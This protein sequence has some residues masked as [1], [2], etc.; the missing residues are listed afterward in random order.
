MAYPSVTY[1]FANDSTADATEVNSNFTDIINGFSDGSKNLNMN[2]ATFAGA[3]T[4]NA[5]VTI[6]NAT[7]DDLTVTSRLASDL[8]PKTD[9]TYD[10]GSTALRYATA[11]IDA[12]TGTTATFDDFF[13]SLGS[14]GSPSY[15][16]AGDTDTG[17]YSSG[18]NTINF[19]TGG[20][21]AMTIASSGDTTFTGR[22]NI[23][24]SSGD[25]VLTLKSSTPKTYDM[26][27]DSTTFKINNT[28]IAN[29]LEHVQGTNTIK[30]PL[31]YANTSVTSA[32]LFVSSSGE[33][34]RATS[35]IRYKKDVETLDLDALSN[36]MSIRP[37]YFYD[38]GD[39]ENKTRAIGFIAE[40][41]DE[42]GLNELV[43]Y[44]D[45]GLPDALNYD[46]FS[47]ILVKAVQEQQS[48]IDNQTAIISNLEA[49]LKALEGE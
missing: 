23:H 24:E 45:D 36:V 22:V 7:T 39:T 34:V 18:A 10:L 14:V 11:W 37:V 3:V 16:F 43:Q 35:S 28:G 30:M 26:V 40:E 31:V 29:I 48:L 20:A 6:G 5:N 4:C 21:T 33:L 41:I 15:S 12:I 42:L 49:R 13:A 47:A 38:K 8:I 9:S 46:K 17:M 32:N 25:A 2:A 19:A 27:V 44:N 1:T